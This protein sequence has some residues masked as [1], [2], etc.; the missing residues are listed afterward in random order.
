VYRYFALIWNADDARAT[1]DAKFVSQRL[2]EVTNEWSLALDRPGLTVFHNGEISSCETRVLTAPSCGVVCGR[3]F[4]LGEELVPHAA[5]AAIE[6]EESSSICSTSGIHLVRHWWGRYVAFFCEPRGK[7]C[8][9]RDPTGG[10]PCFLTTYGGVQIVF[11]DIESCLSLRLLTFTINWK[12]VASY[13]AYSGLQVRETGLNEVMELQPGERA[14]FSSRGVEYSLLWKPSEIASVDPIVDPLRA[15]AAVREVVKQCVHAWASLHRSVVHQLSGGLDSSIVLGCLKSAPHQPRITCIHFHSPDAD[16]DERTYARLV[17]RYMDAELVEC[18]LDPAAV[19]LERLWTVR[20][21]PK[22]WPYLYDLIHSGAEARVA[23]EHAAT[24]VFTGGG[25]DGL[26]VQARSEL[27][28]ADYL[29]N[30]GVRPGVLRVAHD[31]ARI[32][33]T[34][35][36]TALRRGI[37]ATWQRAGSGVQFELGNTRPIVPREVRE[38]VRGDAS[39]AHVWVA[40]EK[41]LAPGLLWQ[42]QSLSIPSPFYESFGESKSLERTPVLMSQPLMELCLRIPTYVWITG[43]RDRAIARRA[44]ADVLPNAVARRTA[45][46]RIDRYN[47]NVADM[48]ASFVRETLLDGVLVKRG[49]LDRQAIASCVDRMALAQEDFEH[50]EVMYQHLSTEVWT[51]KWVAFTTSSVP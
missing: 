19:H 26:F 47:R 27:A 10:L 40:G 23:G 1:E 20:A 8:V 38:S 34:S 7:V 45:K 50:G 21:A 6:G 39:L 33:R 13:V 36:W 14:S 42:I 46:G 3:I 17:A 44:F 4:R 5:G 9:L 41:A 29:R 11:S 16:E 48:N 37:R 25:G 18:Q 22:P 15:I 32:N 12:Y 2:R 43:G 31:V 35:I 28:I 24:G 49:L 51:R 30:R